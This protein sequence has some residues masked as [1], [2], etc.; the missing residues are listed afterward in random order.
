MVIA[1][2][3]GFATRWRVLATVLTLMGMPMTLRMDMGTQAP[4][5]IA[6]TKV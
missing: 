5:E 3:E 6:G 1:P 4:G 2:T